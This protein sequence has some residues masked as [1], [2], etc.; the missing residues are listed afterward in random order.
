MAGKKKISVISRSV[1][2][3][4]EFILSQSRNNIS[5]LSQIEIYLA[6]KE[7]IVKPGILRKAFWVFKTWLW[8]WPLLSKLKKIR[9]FQ[10]C[11][12]HCCIFKGFKVTSLQSSAWLGFGPGPPTWVNFPMLNDSRGRPGFKSWPGRTLKICNFEALDVTAMYFTFLETS[13]LFLYGQERPRA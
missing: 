2:W 1:S 3:A 6:S 5:T 11:K 12:V 13:N 8:P 9:G 10:K 7:T 4:R